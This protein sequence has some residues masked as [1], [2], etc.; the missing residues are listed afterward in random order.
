VGAVL[1]R[2]WDARLHEDPAYSGG[3]LDAW[4]SL[5]ADGLAICR[6]E[7]RAIDD[8]LRWEERADG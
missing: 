5:M 6:I 1:V 2:W 8:F 4:P 3:V 7:E